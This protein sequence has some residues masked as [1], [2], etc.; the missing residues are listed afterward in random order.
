MRLRNGLLGISVAF[1]LVRCGPSPVGP[2]GVNPKFSQPTSLRVSADDNSAIGGGG[3]FPVWNV[4][5][6]QGDFRVHP[7]SGA[8]P[9]EVHVNMCHSSDPDPGISLHY[10]VDWGDQSDDRGF[11]RFDH[12]YANEGTFSGQACV[13]DEIPAHAPGVC[14]KFTINVAIVQFCHAISAT[15]IGANS[16]VGCPT[17][18]TQY[19]S[20]TRIVA[21]NTAQAHAACDDCFGSCF[22]IGLSWIGARAGKASAF[23][24]GGVHQGCISGVGIPGRTC[25]DPSL[26]WAP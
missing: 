11:C 18:A 20:T 16:P 13:W 1:F 15:P 22:N 17:G 2:S 14:D 12:V 10:H 24:Y 5:G 6:A 26:R 23:F 19:C 9:L 4:G 21:T 25:T 8:P 3:A 7:M